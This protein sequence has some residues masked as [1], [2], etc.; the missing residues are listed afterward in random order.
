VEVVDGDHAVDCSQFIGEL[1]EI[2]MLGRRLQQ[3]APSTLIDSFAPERSSEF[4]ANAAIVCTAKKV[5]IT[6]R[7]AIRRP[8]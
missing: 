8:R 2:E 7:A 5:A 1:I 6:A 4:V 3:D